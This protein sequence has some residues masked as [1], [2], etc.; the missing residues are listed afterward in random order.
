MIESP[1]LFNRI[2]ILPHV[3]INRI[4]AR[5]FLANV[6]ICSTDVALTNADKLDSDIGVL[7]KSQREQHHC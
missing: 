1:L 4:V 5:L 2:Q 7:P 3:L 6:E